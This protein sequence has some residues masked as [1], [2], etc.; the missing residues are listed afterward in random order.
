MKRIL[1]LLAAGGLGALLIYI[2][3]LVVQRPHKDVNATLTEVTTAA[4][5]DLPKMLDSETEVTSTVALNHMLQYNYRLVRL[6]ASSADRD[7]LT[8]TFQR[9]IRDNGCTSPVLRDKL[10]RKGITVRFAYYDS[11]YQALFS[12][13]LEPKHCGL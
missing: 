10:L 3:S 8:A 7:A 11:S 9:Q 6:D 13:D 2:A 12:I 1:L 4:N 5:R